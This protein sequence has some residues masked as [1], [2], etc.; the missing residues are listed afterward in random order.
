MVRTHRP[1]RVKDAHRTFRWRRRSQ[2]LSTKI[3]ARD[4]DVW[5]LTTTHGP[6]LRYVT[7]E[8]AVWT[9]RIETALGQIRGWEKRTQANPETVEPG[10]SLGLDDA[11]NHSMV[12]SMAWFGLQ[13]SVDHLSQLADILTARGGAPL[14]PYAPFTL[15]RSALLAAGQTVWLLSGAT[16]VERIK[17][18]TLVYKDEWDNHLKF[19]KDY[20]NDPVIQ[21]TIDPEMAKGME[22]QIA[23]LN[24]Q[25]EEVT[26]AKIG[27]FASTKMLEDAAHWV[28]RHESDG[29]QKRALITEWRM[30]S[31]AAHA[32]Q[33]P[34]NFRQAK[35]MDSSYKRSLRWVALR[36]VETSYQEIWTSVGAATLMARE[37]FRL[38]D[39]RRFDHF[40]EIRRLSRPAV[41]SMSLPPL[42]ISL[43]WLSECHR[44]SNSSPAES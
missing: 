35:T 13:S 26:K 28:T 1:A 10:S 41:L 30:G 12:S 37:G 3:P 9:T 29:W 21:K 11:V 15:T 40:G 24:E 19:L 7:E 34:M 27:Y 43:A 38:W 44:A 23:K 20:T 5:T 33:W 8:D 2:G 25:I 6:N 31:A 16:R 17:R 39:A 42:N 32:R 18:A 14:R 36:Y 22:V 4:V